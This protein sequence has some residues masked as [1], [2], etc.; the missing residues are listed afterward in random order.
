MNIIEKIR[1]EIIKRIDK[2]RISEQAKNELVSILPFLSD[3][4]KSEKP[5]NPVL[6]DFPTTEKEMQDFLA[7]HERIPV[8]ERL[9]SLERILQEQPV[10]GPFT[11]EQIYNFLKEQLVCDGLEEKEPIDGVL[12][13]AACGIKNSEKEQPVCEGLEEELDKW[14][15]KHFHG[16]RDNYYAG[17]YLERTSQLSLARHFYNLG[18]GS[19]EKPN[20]LVS[21]LKHHLATTPKEQLQKEWDELKK[22]DNIGP[23]VQEFLHGKQEKSEIP[24]NLDE[25]AENY[26]SMCEHYL[27]VTDGDDEKP[28]EEFAFDGFKAGAM[29]QKEQGVSKEF[30]VDEDCEALG[31]LF[32]RDDM[33]EIGCMSCPKGTK[34]IV[35]IRKKDE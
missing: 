4:E 14:R 11:G 35:Q 21:E 34:V 30:D 12:Y 28:K 9:N 18:R 33:E 16:K 31:W 25:A 23:T 19:S 10:K 32:N 6:Q 13:A 5:M 3:L 29:W 2:R 20:D 8:P 24:T 15:H 27:S 26:K 7:T 22:W 1:A 17:E